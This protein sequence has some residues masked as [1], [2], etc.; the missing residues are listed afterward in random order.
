VS[1]VLLQWF[2][3]S[4]R[5][6]ADIALAGPECPVASIFERWLDDPDLGGAG[7][8]HGRIDVHGFYPPW[9]AV[10]S[11][12]GPLAY[13]PQDPASLM[14]LAQQVHLSSAAETASVLSLFGTE[15]V[16]GE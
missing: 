10:A 4:W 16:G 14:G 11:T 3:I 8:P 15:D 6:N 9:Q 12:T 2:L 13:R 5:S 7:Q 1:F